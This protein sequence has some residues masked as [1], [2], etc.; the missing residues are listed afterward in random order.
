MSRRIVTAL[1]AAAVAAALWFGAGAVAEEPDGFALAVGQN[2]QIRVPDVD[3]RQSWSLLGVYVVNGDEKADGIHAVYTQPDAV[4]A[5]R[6]TGEFPDGTVLIKELFGTETSD[7]TTGNISRA[8]KTEGWF[9]M[10][11]DATGRYAGNPLWG[12]GWGWAYFAGDDSRTS[13]TKDYQAECKACH[14]PAKNTDWV[15][16]E[17]Y[18]VLKKK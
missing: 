15:Y 10:V 9:V 4:T 18:P 12:D 3:Y 13:P 16:V 7:M 14:V 2:G 11:K 6:E 1:G 5:Y 17:G 8:G